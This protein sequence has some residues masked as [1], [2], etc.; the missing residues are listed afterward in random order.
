MTDQLV[1]LTLFDLAVPLDEVRHAVPR[2]Q[3]PDGARRLMRALLR[4]G[5]DPE[6]ARVAAALVLALD[7]A[8]AENGE[9]A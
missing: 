4:H 7:A 5:L 3:P 8:A 6:H 1:Q 2:R 9:Q